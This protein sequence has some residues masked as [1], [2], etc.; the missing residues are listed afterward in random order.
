MDVT[1]C[2]RARGALDGD[3]QGLAGPRCLA[4]GFADVRRWAEVVCWE[5]AGSVAGREGDVGD[6]LVVHQV[7]DR[8]RRAAEASALPQMRC[9]VVIPLARA[10]RRESIDP[11]GGGRRPPTRGRGTRHLAAGGANSSCGA[12]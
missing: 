12:P 6:L 3:A 9:P 8:F 4:D 5:E 10:A 7:R 2:Y 1:A 11:C